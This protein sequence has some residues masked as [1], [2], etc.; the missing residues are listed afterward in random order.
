MLHRSAT[1]SFLLG[2]L[3]LTACSARVGTDCDIDLARTIAYSPGGSPAYAG[4][5]MLLTSCAGEGSFCHSDV[6][7]ERYGAPFG[8]NFDPFLA[9]DSRFQGDSAAGARHLYEAQLLSHR[10]RDD[11]YAQVVSG[12]MPPGG[13]GTATLRAPYRTY[14][15]ASDATGAPVPSI[16]SAEGR[17]LL[18]N[19]LA[20]GS[21]VVEATAYAMEASC[22]HDVDCTLTHRCDLEHGRCFG[23]GAVT[24]AFL[25][26]SPH[27]TSIYASLL[28]PTCA[29]AL[30]HDAAGAAASGALDLSSPMRAYAALVAAPSSVAACGT[31]V[32]AGE[33]THSLL[34]LKL[35]GTQDAVRCGVAMPIGGLLAPHQV[36]VVRTWIMNGAMMD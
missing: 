3:L 16:R 19:W 5:S 26:T 24:P 7:T 20:C 30:C 1:S 32:V 13:V 14:A 27:W 35:E 2:A 29:V 31:R 25:I 8:M 18:R 4:Q 21:P 33:P 34:M 23:V 9:D 10:F 28:Q 6:A 22:T 12:A 11:I 36:D 17:E 15:D